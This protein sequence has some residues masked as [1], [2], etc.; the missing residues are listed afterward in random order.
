MLEGF[1]F[2]SLTF[3][4]SKGPESVDPGGVEVVEP[5]DANWENELTFPS[6]V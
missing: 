1:Y 5:R 6:Q 3:P 4:E 2:P